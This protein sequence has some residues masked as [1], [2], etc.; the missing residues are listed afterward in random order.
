MC[1]YLEVQLE[2]VPCL[3]QI[4][5]LQRLCLPTTG[6][7]CTSDAVMTTTTGVICS[8]PNATVN[9]LSNVTSSVCRRHSENEEF[10]PETCCMCFRTYEDDVLET[11]GTQ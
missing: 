8:T 4:Q 3:I 7:V 5:L 2:P 9:V 10:D 6:T 11:A 1:K